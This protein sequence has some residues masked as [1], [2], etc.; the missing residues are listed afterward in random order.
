M[1]P[2]LLLVFIKNSIRGKVKTRLA[3]TIGEEQALAVYERLLTHTLRETK[4]LHCDKWICYSHFIPDQDPWL[5]AGFKP[6][7]QQGEDL[8]VRMCNAFKAGFEAGYREIV[9]IGSDCPELS[10][11]ILNEAFQ[12]FNYCPVC[13]GPADDGGYYLLGMRQLYQVLF[14]QK[15]WSTPS[16]FRDTV[17]DL[18]K[19][20][21]SYYS[22]PVL[23][24][25][26]EEKDL[27]R[28]RLL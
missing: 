23:A 26:D 9:I 24:D 19:L 18:K 21:V 15:Q 11:D 27:F 14:G 22:L 10:A 5:E 7:L 6:Y 2:R 3:K 17:E 8:G 1:S 4:T 28:M 20:Q 16:V 25:V 12:S 13:L